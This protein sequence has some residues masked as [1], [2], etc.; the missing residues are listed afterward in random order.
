MG[1]SGNRVSKPVSMGDISSAV[2]YSSLDLGTLITSGIIKWWSKAK[3]FQYSAIAFNEDDGVTTKTRVAARKEA[4]QGFNL[5]TMYSSAA[6]AL[7]AAI[8]LGENV[9]AWSY[10]RPTS[11]FR[12]LDFDGYDSSKNDYDNCPFKYRPEYSSVY[13]NETLPFGGIMELD[14]D[15]S[16]FATLD[17]WYLGVAFRHEDSTTTNYYTFDTTGSDYS[18]PASYFVNLGTYHFCV[19]FTNKS[20]AITDATSAASFYLTPL[21]YAGTVTRGSGSGITFASSGTLNI[22]TATKKSISGVRVRSSGR[23]RTITNV[24]FVYR[25]SASRVW[26]NASTGEA[27]STSFDYIDVT[28]SGYSVGTL[29][30]SGS[31]MTSGRFYM[32]FYRGGSRDYIEL[33]PRQDIILPQ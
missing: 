6:A 5:G 20:K 1:Y 17:G 13:D 22:N 2:G 14:W 21:P 33:V 27:D 32:R 11:Y 24:T 15:A 19:F 16:D 4:N 3:P 8:A 18:I 29:I 23:P 28:T 7:N 25:T 10:Q 31:G 12:M 26:S 30:F 9:F